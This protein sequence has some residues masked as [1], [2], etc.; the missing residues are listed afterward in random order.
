[1]VLMRVSFVVVFVGVGASWGE[2]K[3]VDF[4]SSSFFGPWFGERLSFSVHN[5]DKF[6][7]TGLQYKYFFMYCHQL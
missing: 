7:L 1:M 5:L 2:E 6:K 4:H 3:K